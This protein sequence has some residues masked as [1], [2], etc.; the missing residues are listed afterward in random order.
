MLSLQKS[1]M[2]DSAAFNQICGYIV[3][4]YETKFLRIWSIDNEKGLEDLRRYVE[5][6]VWGLQVTITQ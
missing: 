2:I 3:K 1:T 4:T 6:D 5:N